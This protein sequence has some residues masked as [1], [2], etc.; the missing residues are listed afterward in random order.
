MRHYTEET[1]VQ[2][3]QQK[4]SRVDIIAMV[5]NMLLNY[6]MYYDCSFDYD[7]WIDKREIGMLTKQDYYLAQSLAIKEYQNQTK[8]M[9]SKLALREKSE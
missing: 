7:Y 4:L 9:F 5:A 8:E 6:L 2:P 3:K 1:Y